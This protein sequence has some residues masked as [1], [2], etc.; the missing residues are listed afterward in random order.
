M[1]FSIFLKNSPAKLFRTNFDPANFLFPGYA[2]IILVLENLHEGCIEN[3]KR[4][5]GL[6]IFEGGSN[7]V[8]WLSIP[9]RR[10][11]LPFGHQAK[12][13]QNAGVVIE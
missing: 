12:K 3:M 6:R 13:K 7:S 1:G 9:A 8:S 5:P 4:A 11:G 2:E 10:F